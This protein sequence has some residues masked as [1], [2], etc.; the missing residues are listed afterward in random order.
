MA[1]LGLP[2]A[3]AHQDRS[4]YW[5]CSARA[6]RAA[7]WKDECVHP[8]K[9]TMMHPILLVHGIN[10]TSACFRKMQSVLQARGFDHV[11]AM[12][13]IPSDASITLEAMGE[14][15]MDGVRACQAATGTPT[16]D[17]VAFSMGALAARY[18]LHHLEEQSSVQ[19][20]LVSLSGPHH[21]TLTAHLSW[22]A[23]VRQMRRGSQF[24]RDLNASDSR[25]VEVFSFWSPF[26]LV[27]IPATSSV[28]EGAHNRAFRVMQHHQMLTD[29]RV[30]EAVA[31]ALAPGD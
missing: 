13:I 7:R 27:V 12:D 6:L 2:G 26:D 18:A 15:V 11:H 22:R 25:S 3:L 8:R 28:V 9:L 17:I 24:L 4:R 30:I 10:D 1:A 29:D 31:Q 20:R 19:R 14:Q 21:G 23:G 5:N 16:V